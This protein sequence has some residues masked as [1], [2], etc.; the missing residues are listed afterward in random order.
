M[1]ISIWLAKCGQ[2]GMVKTMWIAWPICFG[3]RPLNCTSLWRSQENQHY[4][5]TPACCAVNIVAADLSIAWAETVVVGLFCQILCFTSFQSEAATLAWRL[6]LIVLIQSAL[7]IK[8]Q[9]SEISLWCH[10]HSSLIAIQSN[11]PVGWWAFTHGRT[12]SEKLSSV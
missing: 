8:F 10:L 4:P 1:C 11:M 6:L 3:F 7:C 12:R 5:L 9:G 2:F